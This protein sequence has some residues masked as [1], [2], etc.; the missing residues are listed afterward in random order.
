MNFGKSVESQI[1]NETIF[2][3]SIIRSKFASIWTGYTR[4]TT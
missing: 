2:Y 1:R 3:L 4:V